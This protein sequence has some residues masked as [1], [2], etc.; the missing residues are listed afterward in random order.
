M[1]VIPVVLCGGS[2]T[3]LW[4]VSRQL[5]PKQ[6]LS[7]STKNSM[8]QETLL[9]LEGL[10][11]DM[12]LAAPCVVCHEEHRFL[13]AEQLRRMGV[14]AATIVLEPEGRN[15]APAAALAALQCI[16]AMRHIGGS[17]IGGQK[18]DGNMRACVKEAQV[19]SEASATETDPIMLVLPA[20]HHIADEE[21]FQN[22][23]TQALPLALDGRLVTFGVIPRHAETGYGYIEQGDP[24]L[25]ADGSPSGA[26]A[27]QGFTEKPVAELAHQFVEQGTH[28]WN[29]G[30]FMFRAGAFLAELSHLAPDILSW[31]KQAMAGAE[32]D[33]D[34]IRPNAAA[35]SS[36]PNISIDHAVMEH[37]TCGAVVPLDAGWNDIGSWSAL[38]DVSD[39]NVAGNS[40]SGDVI[41][42]DTHNCML[43]SER[44]LIAAIGLNDMIVVE[45]ADAVLVAHRDKVQQVREVVAQLQKNCRVECRQHRRVYRPWGSYVLMEEGTRYQVKRITVNP[46]ASLSLQQH[47]HR[48]EHWVVVS[49]TAHIT[50]GDKVA[51][52]TENQSTYIPVGE[53]HRLKNP[54]LIEL[55]L[56]EV[57]SG[58]YLGEDDIVRLEDTFN[59]C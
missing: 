55:E 44:R 11:V 27:L 47:H 23:I 16:E 3:R 57:Q 30:I 59:R 38:W 18:T 14:D 31:C 37:T 43:R 5:Y 20:D 35:F 12:G 7:L 1:M 51:L 34:F 21:A 45:T 39:K 2:G 6:F 17:H 46:G 49:G 22:A 9:R 58:S 42:V 13:V 53:I 56:I 40:I 26:F 28:L 32:R 48:A 41:E 54:G 36:N 8:L 24:L 4:P 19:V 15:T 10:D 29:A 52:I 25:C 50:C 33:L